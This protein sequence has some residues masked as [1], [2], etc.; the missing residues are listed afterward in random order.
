MS[1]NPHSSA[2]LGVAAMLAPKTKFSDMPIGQQKAWLAFAQDHDW[3]QNARLVGGKII[4][5]VTYWYDVNP[6]TGAEFLAESS[7]EFDNPLDM[8]NWAGY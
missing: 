5:C 7:E 3:G 2:L 1:A 8:R 4:G 6:E